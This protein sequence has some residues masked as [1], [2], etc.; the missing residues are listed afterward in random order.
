MSVGAE[1]L[2]LTGRKATAFIEQVAKANCECPLYIDMSLSRM[3][4]KIKRLNCIKKE[5]M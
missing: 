3:D 5:E 1:K 4:F 2:P